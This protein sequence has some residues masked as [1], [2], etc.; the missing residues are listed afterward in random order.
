MDLL[1]QRLEMLSAF[2]GKAKDMDTFWQVTF[3]SLHQNISQ[4]ATY[5]R[6]GVALGRNRLDQFYQRL[7]CFDSILDAHSHFLI[8]L[9]DGG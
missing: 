5:T 1:F 7:G 8:D 4:E 3:S 9:I 2:F 6:L